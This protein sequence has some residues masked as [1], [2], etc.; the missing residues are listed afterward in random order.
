MQIVG[1][2][3]IWYT[4]IGCVSMTSST[5]ASPLNPT[6]A[7]QNNIWARI[8]YR[9]VDPV[10]NEKL[11]D[12]YMINRYAWVYIVTPL[13]AAIPAGILVNFHL[14]ADDEI[15]NEPIEEDEKGGKTETKMVFN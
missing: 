10:T 12:E 7:L 13:I 1:P 9:Y 8:A 15:A 3:L 4:Y 14:R 11:Y 5:T 6:V 2:I